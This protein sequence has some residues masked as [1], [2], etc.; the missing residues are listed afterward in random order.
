MIT[1]N[2]I[3][4]VLND[5]KVVAHY[6]QEWVRLMTAYLQDNHPLNSDTDAP[7]PQWAVNLLLAKGIGYH[8]R[9]R[10]VIMHHWDIT[11]D[12]P[13]DLHI[14]YKDVLKAPAAPIPDWLAEFRE[15]H[16][17]IAKEYLERKD[18]EEKGKKN[19]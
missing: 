2:A 5:D 11:G 16:A 1:P 4:R 17:A 7:V 8:Q 3:E 14:K 13:Q 10:M 12:S 15:K 6:G 9:V 18:K 19:E